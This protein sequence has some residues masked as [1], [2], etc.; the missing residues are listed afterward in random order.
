VER[1]SS[2]VEGRALQP[3]QDINTLGANGPV[4][5]IITGWNMPEMSG[6][7]FIRS[8]RSMPETKDTPMLQAT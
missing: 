7:D 2:T 3:A 6:I 5:V 1:P 8:V 4:D